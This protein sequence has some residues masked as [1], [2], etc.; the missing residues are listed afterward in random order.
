MCNANLQIYQEMASSDYSILK[1]EKA[2]ARKSFLALSGDK[3][4]CNYD[5]VLKLPSLV[6]YTHIYR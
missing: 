3:Q 5:T 2:S 4:T 6:I 1:A